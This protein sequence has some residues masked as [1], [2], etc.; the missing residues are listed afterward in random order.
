MGIWKRI[1]T[2]L[3]ISLNRIWLL[4]PVVSRDTRRGISNIVFASTVIVLLVV[5]AS[6]FLLYATRPATTKTTTEVMTETM[7]Q[8]PSSTGPVNETGQ[9]ATA[10]FVPVQGQMFTRGWAVIAPVGGG[11]YL[12]SIHAE[13]LEAPSMGDYTVEASQNT[14]NIAMVPIGGTNATLSEFEASSSGV[15][16]FSIV[17]MENPSSQFESI[18]IVYLPGMEMTNATVVATADLVMMTAAT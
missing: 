9:A 14:G 16:Q 6:G 12:V 7:T 11:D 13:G 10:A 2:H 15:G 4:F 17:L 3:E 1:E 5:A 8:T 18:S